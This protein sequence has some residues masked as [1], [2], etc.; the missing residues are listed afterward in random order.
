MS[1][2]TVT[3]TPTRLRVSKSPPPPKVSSQGSK[4]ERYV[5]PN[6]TINEILDVVPPH[7]FER[8]FIRSSRYIFQD[9]AIFAALLWIAHTCIPMINPSIIY[10]PHTSL[11]TAAHVLGWTAYA[12]AAGLVGMGWFVVG[13]ECGH[14]AFSP[15]QTFND[16]FGFVIHSS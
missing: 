5:V 8:S 6:L 13:H 7:C 10:L 15:N 4:V 16:I 1:T 11:Y 3:A 9:V 2:I 14:G 12:F